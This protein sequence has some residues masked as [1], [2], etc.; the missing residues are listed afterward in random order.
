M[1]YADCNDSSLACLVDKESHNHNRWPQLFTNDDQR[2]SLTLT[3][4]I[5]LSIGGVTTYPVDACKRKR[6]T[7]KT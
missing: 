6:I 1:I 3:L 2:I 5:F 4:S 7:K